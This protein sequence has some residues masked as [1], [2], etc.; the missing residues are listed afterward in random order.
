MEIKKERNKASFNGNYL[1]SIMLITLTILI[2]YLIFNIVQIQILYSDSYGPPHFSLFFLPFI[3]LF[4]IIL[5]FKTINSL[6]GAFTKTRITSDSEFI[7]IE[8]ITPFKYSSKRV[9]YYQIKELYF[10]ASLFENFCKSGRIIISYDNDKK[11]LIYG[12]DEPI[13]LKRISDKIRDIAF[14]KRKALK[15]KMI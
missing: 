8:I 2:C 9:Y 6:I 7:D 14:K 5:I 11:I 12:W 13:E 1:N 15:D 3:S 10:K 4:A